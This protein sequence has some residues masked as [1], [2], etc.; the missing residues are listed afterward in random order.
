VERGYLGGAKG[1]EG[2]SSIGRVRGRS[3]ADT[4]DRER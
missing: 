4:R 2:E 1:K 3:V